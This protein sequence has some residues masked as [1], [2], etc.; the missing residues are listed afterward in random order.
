MPEVVDGGEGGGVEAL[1]PQLPLGPHDDVDG[2]VDVDHAGPGGVERQV[3]QG[4][5]LGQRRVRGEEPVEHGLAVR[6]PTDDER[7]RVGG[8]RDPV[9]LG[10][11]EEQRRLLVVD[12]LAADDGVEVEAQPGLVERRAVLGPHRLHLV[13]EGGGDLVQPSGRPVPRGEVVLQPHDDLVPDRAQPGRHHEQ[14]PTVVLV[15]GQLGLV[16]QLT[17]PHDLGVGERDQAVADA[18]AD[19]EGHTPQ[20]MGPARWLARA[21]TVGVT[22]PGDGGY[23][24]GRHDDLEG[25]VDRAAQA[26]ERAQTASS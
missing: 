7:R 11:D 18:Q 4:D 9:A 10:I 26:R 2:E 15:A 25:H 6:R 12:E 20:A 22:Q 17:A 24:N 16:G 23:T 8:G 21:D 5:G 19:A 3:G 14:R 13:A 1:L